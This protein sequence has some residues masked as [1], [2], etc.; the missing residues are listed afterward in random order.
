ATFGAATVP[1]V[2]YARY[3]SEKSALR[4]TNAVFACATPL[5]APPHESSRTTPEPV[6]EVRFA[7]I[8][9][10]S[11]SIPADDSVALQMLDFSANVARPLPPP[12]KWW[13]APRDVRRVL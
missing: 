2:Q 6:P 11:A 5:I 7:S 9:L 13:S 4:W 3:C 12:A 1:A 10:S 8:W